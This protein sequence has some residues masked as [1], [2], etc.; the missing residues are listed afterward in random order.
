MTIRHSPAAEADR[1]RRRIR[2]AVVLVVLLLV[3][4]GASLLWPR[5]A[6]GPLGVATTAPT[7]PAGVL[8]GQVSA[9]RSGRLV[10][11]TVSR[12]GA[13]SVLRFVPGWSADARLGLHEP[14]G[15]L[16]ARPGEAVALLGRPGP[17]GSVDGCAAEGRVWT[18]T[19]VRGRV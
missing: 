5:P 12:D 1:R 17:V 3:L 2:L 10:C 19:G 15:A 18:I 11:Y 4:A 14:G 7:A 8:Q 16:A 13:T 9:T 6:S